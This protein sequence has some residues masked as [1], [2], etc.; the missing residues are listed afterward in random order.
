M[1]Y[2]IGLG[3]LRDYEQARS[4]PDFPVMAYLRLIIDHPKIAQSLV[5]K[6]QREGDAA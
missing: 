2:H 6:L 1:R 3:R 5:E 4:E